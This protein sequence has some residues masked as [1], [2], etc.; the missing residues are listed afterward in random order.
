MVGSDQTAQSIN[1]LLDGNIFHKK[2]S[3]IQ[4]I[5]LYLLQNAYLGYLFL[6]I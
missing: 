5:Y 4:I 1:V 2:T 3:T 6:F